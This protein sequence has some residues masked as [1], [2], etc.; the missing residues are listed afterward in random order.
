LPPER[1]LIELLAR[2]VAEGD[3]VDW[4]AELD[5]AL[6][7]NERRALQQLRAV[8]GL[9]RE[10]K[11]VSRRFTT[12]EWSLVLAAG[13]AD[14]PE[15][16]KALESLCR[17]YWYPVYAEVRFAGY[18]AENSRDLTQG[19]FLQ[20]LERK[21]LTV[22]DPDRGKFRDFLKTSIKNYLSDEAAR[23]QAQKRGGGV[24]LVPLDLADAEKQYA[25]ELAHTRTPEKIFDRRWAR[26]LLERA[27]DRLRE[28]MESAGS[29]ERFER[30]A[31]LLTG[32]DDSTRYRDLA[33]RWGTTEAAIKMA[34]HRMRRRLR[35]LGR[36]EVA[37]TVDDP[38]EVDEEIRFLLSAIGS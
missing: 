11:G 13:E 24:S 27:L 34:V 20:L 22:A 2:A 21:A 10:A 3:R 9:A 36:L 35:Q 32:S 31:P 25:L 8:D 37:H 17:R 15:S 4:T 33:T 18:D 14:G 5:S 38:R 16:R 12:T 28:E 30:L 1:S 23:R 19:F 26:A 7:S 6:T 29:L